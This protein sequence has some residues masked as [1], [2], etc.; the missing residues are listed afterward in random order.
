[1][2]FRF[3][4]LGIAAFALWLIPSD[5]PAQERSGKVRL[6]ICHFPPGNPDAGRTMTISESAW[7]AHESHGDT[8]GPCGGYHEDYDDHYVDE[9]K[10]G[11]KGKKKGRKT[12]RDE[13]EG[14]DD[15]DEIDA[16]DRVAESE[17]VDAADRRA[18]R[19]QRRAERRER[20]SRNRSE[21]PADA[22]EAEGTA[23]SDDAGEVEEGD[24][25]SGTVNAQEADQRPARERRA[26][27]RS[28]RGARTGGQTDDSGEEERGFFRGVRQFFGFGG[29]G[30]EE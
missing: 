2:K 13:Y 14:E 29:N 4:T 6:T 20:R 30:D 3:L 10:R 1:M 11:K 15:D 8:L 5:S 27:R 23:A 9:H 12:Y 19:E 7:G 24:A 26:A 25:G 16:D 17:E 18:R 28:P 21:A 22:G